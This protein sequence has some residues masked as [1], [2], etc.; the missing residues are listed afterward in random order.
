MHPDFKNR[1]FLKY[2]SIAGEMLFTILAF[3]FL[4]LWLDSILDYDKKYLT[5]ILTVIGVV[6]AVYRT[7]KNVIK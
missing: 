2:S 5:A 7:I 4:G 3:V 6:A 1:D